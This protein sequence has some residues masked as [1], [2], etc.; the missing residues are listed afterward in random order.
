VRLEG[1]VA[2]PWVTELTVVDAAT[3]QFLPGFLFSE[4]Y[5]I[6]EHRRNK[7]G[8]LFTIHWISK[9]YPLTF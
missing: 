3:R 8:E 9:L 5:D 1:N 6:F 7:R 4:L 2:A